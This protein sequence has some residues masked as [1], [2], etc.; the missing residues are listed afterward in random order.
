MIQLGGSLCFGCVEGFDTFRVETERRRRRSSKS[1]IS[2][3]ACLGS[4]VQYRDTGMIENVTR[5]EL[6]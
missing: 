3:A 1:V 5:S 2:F 6:H 4:N